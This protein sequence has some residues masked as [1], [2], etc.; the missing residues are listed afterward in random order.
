MVGSG[1]SVGA[2][3]AEAAEPVSRKDFCK[4][5]AI[6]LK[7]LSEVR[8]WLRLASHRGWAEPARA[9]HVEA[10]AVELKLILG[11]ILTRTRRR[12]LSDKQ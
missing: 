1:T 4:H 6:A 10:E 7:E 2:N 8:F 11:S 5:I 9:E 12:G 3:L